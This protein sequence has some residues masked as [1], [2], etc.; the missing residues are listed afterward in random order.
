M[1]WMKRNSKCVIVSFVCAFVFA[2]GEN[3]PET[4]T[5]R[6]HP[7]KEY[8]E[9]CV[10]KD[11]V[12]LLDEKSGISFSVID[13]TTI[14]ITST[15]AQVTEIGVGSIILCPATDK[16]PNGFLGKVE[17]IDGDRYVTG[18]VGLEEVFQ[19]LEIEESI[20]LAPYLADFRDEDGTQ[21]PCEIVDGSIWDSFSY[22]QQTK[23]AETR[24]GIPELR[25]V[26]LS[27]EN[28]HFHGEVFS[29]TEMRVAIGVH[30]GR[31]YRRSFDFAR[32]TG[33]SG[34][35]TLKDWTRDISFKQKNGRLPTILLANGLVVLK[36]GWSISAG[37]RMNGEITWQ[38]KMML[39]ME[40]GVYSIDIP[41]DSRPSITAEKRK[42]G[43][44]VAATEIEIEGSVTPYVKCGLHFALYDR[45]ILSFGVDL[46]GGLDVTASIPFKLSN[47]ELL[48]I[49][50]TITISPSLGMELYVSSILFGLLDRDQIER[51]WMEQENGRLSMPFNPSWDIYEIP[52][53][54]QFSSGKFSR[55]A[56]SSECEVNLNRECFMTAK[57][58]G[59]AFF[60]NPTTAPLAHR[61]MY[62]SSTRADDSLSGRQ[63]VSYDGQA[64]FAR[65]YVQTE[66]GQYYYGEPIYPNLC[67]D[68]NHP[69]LIDLGLP[70]G[71]K[72]LC[73]NLGATNPNNR[74]GVYEWC[75]DYY[76]DIAFHCPPEGYYEYTVYTKYVTQKF[77]YTPREYYGVSG[78]HSVIIE[79]D[80]K[81]RLDLDDDIAYELSGGQWRIPTEE[82]WRELNNRANASW[83]SV[84][85]DNRNIKGYNIYCESGGIFLPAGKDGE[86]DELGRYP[87]SI[88]W[89][90]ETDGTS[91]GDRANSYEPR[92]S[93]YHGGFKRWQS[94][95]IRPVGI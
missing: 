5:V 37:L 12:F 20:D 45:R 70:S 64:K 56:N 51:D 36:P 77:Q 83:E 63:E 54:P 75:P 90:S 41:N 17:S 48:N 22:A 89:T 9:S 33:V 86:V 43:S 24:A 93:F 31:V 29:Q 40:N 34:D 50:P 80:N 26:S 47:Q 79:A 91:Y 7:E 42:P 6:E 1:I 82:E 76:Q 19:E 59:V 58:S 81:T 74:G 61:P 88:Y 85:D 65:P 10:L 2:C 28:E 38:G 62:I 92:G 57:E 25:T 35:I 23:E 95:R 21:Y 18:D 84:L 53:L 32:R 78:S 8:L 68:E 73:C 14:Q 46:E 87:S 52:L 16:T 94:L 27:F 60:S 4:P 15:R 39:E 30:E 44:F 67:P 66:S 13:P 55:K 11:N 72:W 71:T 3:N 69:H 49:N